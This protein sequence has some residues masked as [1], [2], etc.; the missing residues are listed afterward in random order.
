MKYVFVIE[1]DIHIQREDWN[2]EHRQ[3][4]QSEHIRKL[5]CGFSWIEPWPCRLYTHRGRHLMRP[6]V[7]KRVSLLRSRRLLWKSARA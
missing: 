3:I 2:Q 6:N 4:V 5:A 1:R 7:T